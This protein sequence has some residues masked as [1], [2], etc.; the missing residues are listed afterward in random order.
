MAGDGSVRIFVAMPFST[1]GESAPWSDIDEIRQEFLEPVSRKIGELLGVS[2]QLV[3]EDEKASAGRIH[4]SMF[5]EAV[6]ADIYIAD[7]TGANA[8]VYLEL[9][10]RWALRDG[11]TIPV[12]QE[13]SDI[14]FNASSNRA[15]LYGKGPA[16]LRK[17]IERVT[18][19]A[20]EGFEDGARCD[21]P[22]RDGIPFVQISRAELDDLKTLIERLKLEQTEGLV[23][24]AAGQASGA[25][26]DSHLAVGSANATVASVPSGP[27]VKDISGAPEPSGPVWASGRVP[28]IWGRVPR[29]NKNFTG[30]EDLL[31]QLR[32]DMG[33]NVT[34]TA[35]HALH[36]LGGVGKT[37]V[38]IEYAHKYQSEYDVV[39][40]ISAD[41]PVLVRSS[42]AG[43]APHLGLPPATATGIEDAAMAVLDSLRRGD[44]YGRWL[45]V[46]DNA[47]QPED[48]NDIIPRGSGHV[49][50]TSRNHRWQSVAETVLVNVFNRA[51]SVAFLKKRV[52]NAISDPDATRLA[53]ELG[54]LPLALEQAGALQA[55]TGMS[56]NE[57]LQLLKEQ[58]SELLAEKKP[59]EYPI[60]M[61]AAWKLSVSKLNEQ[62][63]EAVHLLRCCAFFG[64][65]PIPRDVFIWASQ[66]VQP[67]LSGL[68]A[69]PILLNNAIG[70]LGRFALARIDAVSRTIQ[71]HR[72]IQAL[73]REELSPEQQ[74]LFRHDVRLLLAAAAPK[75]PD[76]NVRWPLYAELAAHVVPSGSDEC[77]DPTVRKFALGIA[78]YL[79]QSG[80]RPSSRALLERLL[81]RWKADSGADHPDVLT[82]QWHLGNTLRDLGEYQAAYDL[83]RV[84]LKCSRQILGP[85][86]EL[87]LMLM[88][89][90]GADLRA[91]GEFAAARDLDEQSRRLHEECLGATDPRTLRTM[92][93]FGLDY[94]LNSDYQAARELHQ[95]TYVQ[96]NEATSEVSK[97]DVLASCSGLARAV[98]LCGA[99]AEARCLSNDAYEF[100]RQQLGADHFWTLRAAK[101]LSIALRRTAAYKEALELARDVFE[102]CTRLF[103]AGHPDTMGAALSLINILR[104][105]GEIDEAAKLAEDTMDRYPKVYGADHPYNHGCAGNLALLLRLRG[106][107]VGA[108]GL[109]ETCLDGLDAK[110]TRD[111]HYPLTVATNLASDIAG[112][113]D[114]ADA[115]KLGEDTLARLRSLLGESHPL[116]L[117]CAANLAVDMRTH[118]A[119]EEASRLTEDT[120]ERYKRTLGLG[121]PDTVFAR[122]GRR[123]DFDFDPP[124]IW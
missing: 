58:T 96:Q 76:D 34:A 70:E 106:D 117:G 109:N 26:A 67:Q 98:R 57:H 28:K 63:P 14:R 45:L 94:E 4:K 122:E 43:L 12:C 103:G 119:K 75:N 55:E 92:N 114:A 82:A 107:L 102:R 21:S 62:L 123:L 100:G 23:E 5:K 64:A 81:D 44:P 10:V 15:I 18:K 19:A 33:T 84:T 20:I 16:L 37:Q 2:P 69:K 49:L 88:N 101:E 65:E 73:L 61:T 11:V 68:L 111:H 110:L 112:L 36:G 104:T 120:L 7:L 53:Q 56:V 113:G 1:M 78:R 38:A 17:A 27:L 13:A 79:Y 32:A 47:D 91:R 22:V 31:L 59:S 50:I 9:G 29:R 30:R 54:D 71:V 3:I 83:T 66:D 118:G 39:W 35:P 86:S 42:L 105:V 87:T 8:N 60:P 108:R 121:H 99:Y 24:K 40:W 93:S 124:P 97:S 116:T 72:L 89:G 46:F 77:Q 90:F 6:D 80:D 115:R 25:I 95:L 74:D 52:A 85:N 51:E 48:I 41:Q